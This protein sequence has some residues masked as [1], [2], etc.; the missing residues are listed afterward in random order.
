VLQAFDGIIDTN[1]F[2]NAYS[3]W[4]TKFSLGQVEPVPD[5]K[6]FWVT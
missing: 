5:I 1:A 2:A 4:F 6:N 3:D